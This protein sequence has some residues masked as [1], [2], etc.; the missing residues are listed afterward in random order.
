[1]V[2]PF[3][4]G[5]LQEVSLDFPVKEGTGA[6]VI[7]GSSMLPVFEDGDLVGYHREG[8]PPDQVVGRTCVLRLADGRVFIKKL[9]RGSQTGLFTL[10]SP[11]ADD[12]EDVAVEWAAPYRFRIPRDE[13]RSL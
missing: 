1:M 10:T 11:S 9:R 8:R 2:L 4:D 7:R 12:I 13:W 5:P 6:V 3:N